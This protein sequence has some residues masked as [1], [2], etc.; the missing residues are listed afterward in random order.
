MSANDSDTSRP[1]SPNAVGLILLTAVIWGATPVAISYSIVS[2]PPVCVAAIRFALAAVFML[3]WCRLENTSVRL[4]PGQLK[5]TLIAATLLFFQIATFNIGTDWSNS[6]H[7]TMLISTFVFWVVAIE[8]FVTKMDRISL[9]KLIGLLTAGIGVLIVLSMSLS[10]REAN[11]AH[12]DWPTLAGDTVLVA[13]AFLL[14]I[15]I[16]YIKQVLKN[17]EPAKLVFWHNVFA[18][19][20]FVIYTLAFEDTNVERMNVAAVLSLVYQ[21]IFVAG[22]CFAVQTTLLKKYSATRISI[23]SFVTPL[24]GVLIAVLL[25][26]DPL[27]PWLCLSAILV[28]LGIYLVNVK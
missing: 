28:A 27:S 7:A 20:L 26:D 24:F 12:Q 17:I 3:F 14:S 4:R 25:R 18:V 9:R 23:F 21:G 2:L 8:H 6:S 13:S 5:P 22:F 11:V 15:R 16:V 10:K 19:V 1:L